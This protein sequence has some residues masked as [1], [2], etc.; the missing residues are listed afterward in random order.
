MLNT[1]INI[2]NHFRLTSSEGIIIWH[3]YSKLECWHFWTTRRN[4][5]YFAVILSLPSRS[6]G[7]GT[8]LF[9][10]MLPPS[11]SGPSVSTSPHPAWTTADKL[12]DTSN[13]QLILGICVSKKRHPFITL[14]SQTVPPWLFMNMSL[15][16]SLQVST[17]TRYEWYVIKLYE[18][19]AL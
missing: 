16:S 7:G 3:N 9:S 5:I 6:E 10:W 15:R 2:Q 8:E 17:N 12:D 11:R 14:W 4:L 18:Q 19:L 1:V 13:R